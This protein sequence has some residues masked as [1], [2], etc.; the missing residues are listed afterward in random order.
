MPFLIKTYLAIRN[1]VLELNLP[2]SGLQTK[3]SSRAATE[4]L[5][6]G[7]V[8]TDIFLYENIAG[9]NG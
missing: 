5:T 4:V 2:D 9:E 3:L 8:R 6:T 7:N 1:R